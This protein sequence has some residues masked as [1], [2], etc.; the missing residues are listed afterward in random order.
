MNLCNLIREVFL[1]RAELPDSIREQVAYDAPDMPLYIHKAILSEYSPTLSAVC[2]WH[3]D[4]EFMYMC[5]GYMDYNVDGEIYHMRAGDG[6]F[7]NSNHLHFGFSPDGSDSEFICILLT[8]EL[9]NASVR[10]ERRFI[11]PVT[12]QESFKAQVLKKDDP[13]HRVL[14]DLIL[15]IYETYDA[16]ND[17]FE[18]ELQSLFFQVW[19]ELY[20]KAPLEG[21]T[22]LASERDR[23][24]LK[25][26]LR[27]LHDSYGQRVTAGDIAAVGSMSQSKCF[28]LF[29]KYLGKTPM[30]VLT[31]YR[32]KVACELLTGTRLSIT[33]IAQQTG[34]SGSSYFTERF[35]QY[36]GKS[37]REYR[38]SRMSIES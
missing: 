11:L 25:H 9:L 22:D 31:E 32:L 38:N 1:V 13:A 7:V 12:E 29:Q 20:R 21:Q 16:G 26:M 15:S 19:L 33:E 4:V 37:P 17:G 35:R 23:M 10:I 27:Y 5:R 6:I 36:Y 3:D 34:F 14:L 18:L 28:R 24:K 8:P 30:E 2:H